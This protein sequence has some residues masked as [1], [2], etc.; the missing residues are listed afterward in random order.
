MDDSF[1]GDFD[2]IV[3]YFKGFDFSDN[4]S[5]GSDGETMVRERN[6]GAFWR[7]GALPKL[8]TCSFVFETHTYL[9]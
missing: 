3:V 7:S 6:W 5:S 8:Q 9:F 4:R 1:G 2:H